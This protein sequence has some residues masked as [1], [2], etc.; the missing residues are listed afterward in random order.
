MS[1]TKFL[2]QQIEPCP[3]HSIYYKTSGP[4]KRTLY[5]QELPFY[6]GQA[7]LPNQW[8][9]VVITSDLQGREME[10]TNRLIGEKVS[11]E[12]Q[13]M[14]DAD[15]IPP[16]DL[17]ITV[18]DLYDHPDCNKRSAYGDVHN[19]WNAFSKVSQQVVG[20]H[21]NHDMIEGSL[22]SNCYALD[23]GNVIALGECSIGGISGVTGNPKRNQR[24]EEE[25]FF[26]CLNR[27]I[28][29]RPDIITL[30][31]GPDN[32]P[33]KGDPIIRDFLQYY[34]GSSIFGHCHWHNNW[35]FELGLGQA[36]NVDARV[37]VLLNQ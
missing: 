29:K 25:H 2:I 32:S 9:C 14:I 26:D 20:V 23:N 34:S 28:S 13:I 16:V 19:V 3:F 18:G 1:A 15:I 11:E 8:Q 12:L 7:H 37:V 27:L 35:F 36:L 4:K 31:Q 24:K 6:F 22:N 5:Q 30:H 21:G 10:A 17:M 33:E